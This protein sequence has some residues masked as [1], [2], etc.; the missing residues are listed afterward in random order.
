MFS[1]F[2]VLTWEY[3][4]GEHA[5]WVGDMPHHHRCALTGQLCSELVKLL[6]HVPRLLAG[7]D[8]ERH[9][10]P[11]QR[12]PQPGGEAGGLGVGVAGLAVQRGA[13]VPAQA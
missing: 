4:R 12:V 10:G 6:V 13:P 1:C 8:G 7:G 5:A 2:E 11:G 3:L 9:L